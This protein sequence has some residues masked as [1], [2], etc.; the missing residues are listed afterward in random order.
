MILM[1]RIQEGNVL[2]TKCYVNN[3]NNGFYQILTMQ[4][5]QCSLG[6]F[7]CTYL[8]FVM[9]TSLFTGYMC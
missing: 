5:I 4:N 6:I 8:S 7:L 3:T 9:K 1:M 2:E